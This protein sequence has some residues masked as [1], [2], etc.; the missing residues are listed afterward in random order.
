MK[1]Y[2]LSIYQP[3]GRGTPDPEFLA[4][5]MRELG[6]IRQELEASGCWVFGQGLHDPST[7]TVLRP[8]Q[9]EVLVTDAPFVEGK[10]YLG[11]FTILRAPTWTPRWSGA[12]ATRSPPPCRSRFARSRARPR[13]ERARR[14]S[15]VPRGVRPRGSRPRPPPRRPRP[16]RGSGA[17]A[18]AVALARW[19]ETGIPPSPAGWIITTARNRAIDRLR[20]E[21]SRG[22]RHAEAVRLHTADEPPEEGPVRDDRL[23][24]IFTC[25]HP[26]LAPA[27]RVALTLRL[28][29][30]LTHRRDRPRLPGTGADDGAADRAGQGEDPARPDPV[31]GAA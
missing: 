1:Q 18:F 15:G 3:A 21:A 20:R 14:G 23:R 31:P 28:L 7:A 10:E 13:A 24:L 17:E 30:G 11:G 22:E 16:R 29:G 6:A 2:L 27:S 26:A 4:G 19:P 25:C 5:V 12:A 9:G 8:Q